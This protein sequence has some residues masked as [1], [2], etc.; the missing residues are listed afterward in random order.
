MEGCRV[1]YPPA[2]EEEE[3]ARRMINDPFSDFEK[4]KADFEDKSVTFRVV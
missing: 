1:I 2:R 4:E 3:M